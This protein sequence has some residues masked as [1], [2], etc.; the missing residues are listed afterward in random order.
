MCWDVVAAHSMEKADNFGFAEPFCFLAGN[1]LVCYIKL[2]GYKRVSSH[3]TVSSWKQTKHFI[4][5]RNGFYN[6]R[7]GE[8]RERDKDHAYTI[9]TAYI[10]A[11]HKFNA[12]NGVRCR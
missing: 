6:G 7:G 1:K 2:A 4:I 5:R 9:H 3:G 11:H 8:T 12:R 10:Y